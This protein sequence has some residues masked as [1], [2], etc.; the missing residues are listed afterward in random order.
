[1]SIHTKARITGFWRAATD[2]S[3]G[4]R[5]SAVLEHG[6]VDEQALVEPIGSP[7][8]PAEL[9]S[10]ATTAPEVRGT[11]L[12]GAA[13][14]DSSSFCARVTA[15]RTSGVV[16]PAGFA[17]RLTLTRGADAPPADV[18]VSDWM[19]LVVTDRT[20]TGERL[21]AQ[22]GDFARIGSGETWT[23]DV[24]TTV[25]LAPGKGRTMKFAESPLGRGWTVT[26]AELDAAGVASEAG[27]THTF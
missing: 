1:M 15:P 8:A 11:A 10:E 16:L 12:Y 3:V 7:T 21:P 24:V 6:E 26:F 25:R 19:D 9:S 27:E 17:F 23:Y 18:A 22:P 5:A 20:S 14:L 13:R 4:G 2:A